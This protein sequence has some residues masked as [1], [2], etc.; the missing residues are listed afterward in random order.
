MKNN[1]FA[2][3]C[4]PPASAS[5]AVSVFLAVVHEVKPE[6]QSSL[7]YYPYSAVK[8]IK[9]VFFPNFRATSIN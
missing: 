2:V 6:W 9:I 7:F 1:L 3:N 5:G 4:H 8:S